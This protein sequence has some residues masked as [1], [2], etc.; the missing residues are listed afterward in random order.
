MAVD[1]TSEDLLMPAPEPAWAKYWDELW[2]LLTPLHG[3]DWPNVIQ[4]LTEPDRQLPDGRKLSALFG[5]GWQPIL[6]E[7]AERLSL[8][9]RAQ[10]QLG[11]QATLRLLSILG[12]SS[13]TARW[14]GNRLWPDLCERV[15]DRFV[16]AKVK[17]PGPY[18]NRGAEALR[19]DLT[20]TRNCSRT[21]CSRRAASV[22]LP[23]ETRGLG[24]CKSSVRRRRPSTHASMRIYSAGIA[25]PG[26]RGRQPGRGVVRQAERS[27][28]TLCLRS[29]R[30]TLLKLIP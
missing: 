28:R 3:V 7:V 2:T 1:V 30:L 15:I 27:R 11:P 9:E 25:R 19:R 4:V 17:L 24:F 23:K 13:Y 26:H 21:T 10:H 5:A 8:F 16:Q 20:N 18:G 6:A 22:P 14:W 29:S 12:S